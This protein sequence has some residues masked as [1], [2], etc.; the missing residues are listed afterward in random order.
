SGPA[1]K[2]AGKK[3]APA[4][5]KSAA[6]G[7]KKAPA[8]KKP[9]KK[10]AEEKPT[11]VP[12]ELRAVAEKLV[13]GNKRQEKVKQAGKKSKDELQGHPT[14]TALVAHYLENSAK[15]L[16][17]KELEEKTGLPARKLYGA[18]GYLKKQGKAWN[19]AWGVYQFR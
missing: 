11:E 7:K 16:T 17:T 10:A 8:A 15:G 1:V 6:A 9:R 18:L 5:K 12:E 14:V 4:K 3:P 19:P 2:K 13:Q